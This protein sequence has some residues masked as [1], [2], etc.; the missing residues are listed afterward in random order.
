MLKWQRAKGRSQ[1]FHNFCLRGGDA[2]GLPINAAF[3]LKASVFLAADHFADISSTES[4][5]IS[6]PVACTPP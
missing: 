1:L 6:R 3:A 4:S 2:T 5:T